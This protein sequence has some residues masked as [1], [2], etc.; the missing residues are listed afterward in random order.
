MRPAVPLRLRIEARRAQ[1]RLADIPRRRSFASARVL[2]AARAPREFPHELMSHS[3]KLIR[4]VDPRWMELQENKV[5]NLELA[6]A[7]LDGLL[8]QPGEVFSFCRTIGRTTRRRGYIEGLETRQ[9]RLVGA[10]GGGLCQLS[11]LIY[12]MVLHLDLD[13]VERHRHETDLFPDDERTVPFGMG[14]TVFYNY[15]DLRFRNSLTQP[16]VLRVWVERPL[17]RGAILSTE[18]LSFAVEIRETAHRFVRRA[19]GSV[20]RENTVEKEVTYSDGRP[21]VVAEIARNIGRVAYSIPQECLEGQ[22]IRPAGAADLGAVRHLIC[23]TIDA[24]YTGVYPPRAV[25]FFKRF[26]SEEGISERLRTGKIFVAELAESPRCIVGTGT[27]V[28]QEILGVFVDPDLQGSGL[29]T[30]LMKRLEDEVRING[31]TEA[32]LDVSL[33]S[34]GFYEALGYGLIEELSYDLGEGQRLDYWG[35]GK[36]LSA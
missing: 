9:G 15:R 31:G 28:G 2:D 8:I 12:W 29:G 34:R 20:W 35:A 6:C 26:H 25:D 4:K 13:I 5:H 32:K 22:V 3:S 14:A 27:V 24:C 30:A 10:P 1:R 23:R 19:D 33:P 21:P 17:L 16:L 7:K 36:R 11:N 18:P